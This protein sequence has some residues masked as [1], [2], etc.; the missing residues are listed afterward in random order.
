M[1]VLTSVIGSLANTYIG[2]DD[3]YTELIKSPL[4]PPSYVF[5]I[6]WP[7]LYIM[8]AFVSFKVAEKISLIFILQL[9]LNAAWSWILSLIHIS[10]PTRPY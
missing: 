1:V 3:W 2:S 7:I 9:V 6:V 8:M 10:E 4:N 5:G